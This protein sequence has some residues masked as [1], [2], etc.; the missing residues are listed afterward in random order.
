MSIRTV[1]KSRIWFCG[2]FVI[3]SLLALFYNAIS[4]EN[5]IY[6]YFNFS[7]I[8]N[9]TKH[10]YNSTTNEVQIENVTDNNVHN[11]NQPESDKISK[12]WPPLNLNIESIIFKEWKEQNIS[13]S[14]PINY[15][16]DPLIF[17]KVEYINDIAKHYKTCVNISQKYS[18][19][20][21]IPSNLSSSK[22]GKHW[23][24]YD[25]LCLV[26]TPGLFDHDQMYGHSNINPFDNQYYNIDRWFPKT[27]GTNP[28][29]CWQN[30]IINYLCDVEINNC[31]ILKPITK[32]INGRNMSVIHMAITIVGVLAGQVASHFQAFIPQQWALIYE[33]LN[34][35]NNKYFYD[36]T[37]ITHL[38]GISNR[39]PSNY[40][41]KGY[42][43]SK[44]KLS[45]TKTNVFNDYINISFAGTF[46]RMNSCNKPIHNVFYSPFMV[47]T[48]F[49]NTNDKYSKDD[50]DTY[51]IIPKYAM[52]SIKDK[53][54]NLNINRNIV[55]YLDRGG[56]NNKRGIDNNQYLINNLTQFIKERQN[57]LN[58]TFQ[59][60]HHSRYRLQDENIFCQ[61][62]IIIGPHGGAF[63]NLNSAQPGT[64]VIE[65]IDFWHK[66]GRD[67]SMHLRGFVPANGLNYVFYTPQHFD[68]NVGSMYVDIHSVLQLMSVVYHKI[69]Q[70]GLISL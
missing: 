65:F 18:Y 39:Y 9:N 36:I 67:R 68:F 11:L 6:D 14:L 17:S 64:Y 34:N 35:L 43:W 47:Q 19:P 44:F 55:L 27:F 46:V 37:I 4:L 10:S 22:L 40:N 50:D 53:L 48:F 61:A 29:K 25:Q 52:F 70:N 49:V 69:Q 54:C 1:K 57:I 51:M 42:F 2:S 16:F 21:G 24:V 28:T 59:I 20:I 56:I 66:E 60:F 31:N 62:A 3:L 13:T 45:W 38:D 30:T 5:G 33:L 8:Y 32:N 63:S 58:Y 15:T 12:P 23:K 7:S 41:F 26:H